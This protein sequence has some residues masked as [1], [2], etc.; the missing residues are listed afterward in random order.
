MLK[1][2]EIEADD[3]LPSMKTVCRLFGETKIENIY[4]KIMNK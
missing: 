4:K 2:R 3:D 1:I